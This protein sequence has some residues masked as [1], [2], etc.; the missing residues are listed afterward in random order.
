MLKHR[1]LNRFEYI[2]LIFTKILSMNTFIETPRLLVKPPNMIDFEAYYGLLSDS[3]VMR[4][5]GKFRKY[6]DDPNAFPFLIRYDGELAGF[7]IVNKSGSEP[8]ID[9]LMA[10]FFIMRK[11]KRQG[12]GRQVAYQCFDRFSGVWEVM[13]F[14]G[15]ESTYRFWRAVIKHYSTQPPIEY[16]RQIAHFKN[17]TYNI[18]KLESGKKQ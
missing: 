14:P 6:W 11:F 2:I 12:I 8:G 3:E 5:I 7:A 13:V 16:T 1:K 18:F 10:Q 17:K 4:Y 9:Y 15:C